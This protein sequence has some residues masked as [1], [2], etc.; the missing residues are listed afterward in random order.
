MASDHSTMNTTANS[1]EQK[2]FA[3]TWL[4]G[5]SARRIT[6]SLW[7]TVRLLESI[8]AGDKVSIEVEVLNFYGSRREKQ[9]II[10]Q[11]CDGQIGGVRS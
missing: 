7:G 2:P 6:I 4:G 1:E 3:E 10:I 11:I 9:W 5:F 8:C